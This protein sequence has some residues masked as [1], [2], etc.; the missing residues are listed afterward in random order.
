MQILNFVF[1]DSTCSIM[2]SFTVF[3]FFYQPPKNSHILKPDVTMTSNYNAV[4]YQI[5]GGTIE[6]FVPA[7]N[8]IVTKSVNNK[9]GVVDSNKHRYKQIDDADYYKKLILNKTQ[10]DRIKVALTSQ[11]HLQNDLSTC[12]FILGDVFD[13]P[14]NSLSNRVQFMQSTR[15]TYINSLSKDQIQDLIDTDFKYLYFIQLT[16]LDENYIATTKWL[17]GYDYFYFENTQY[18]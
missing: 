18:C 17:E 8:V 14:G 4:L 3:I 9:L 16:N 5:R 15:D 13:Y 7:L 6:L 11:R 10:L 1:F 12:E 2:K